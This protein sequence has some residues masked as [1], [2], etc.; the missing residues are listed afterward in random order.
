M[1]LAAGFLPELAQKLCIILDD[2][3]DVWTRE[4]DKKLVWQIQAQATFTS[5]SSPAPSLDRYAALFSAIHD[6][7]F[8][9]DQ[10][11]RVPLPD[12]MKV[13]MERWVARGGTNF[14]ASLVNT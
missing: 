5:Y 11:H 8:R 2:R 3:T 1:V 6:Y 13:G 10:Q 4:S 7:V 12:V 14:F 9:Y